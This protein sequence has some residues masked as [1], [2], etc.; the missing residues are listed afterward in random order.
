MAVLHSREFVLFR[1]RQVVD[2]ADVVVSELLYFIEAITL[3]VFR[4]LFVLQHS[5][6]TFIGVSP[7][8][9]GLPCGESS[10]I[11]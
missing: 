6:Q 4:N 11:S 8:N 3:V 1:F 7:E 10:A 2:L 5:L 9:C